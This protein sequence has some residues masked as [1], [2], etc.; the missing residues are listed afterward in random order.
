MQNDDTQTDPL[1]AELSERFGPLTRFADNSHKRAVGG[2]LTRRDLEILNWLG[3]ICY[4][5]AG[6]FE[7]AAEPEIEGALQRFSKA[8]DDLA[9]ATLQL[10]DPQD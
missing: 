1:H 3:E 7:R 10:L 6:T 4:S 9:L 8:A 2:D 5:I